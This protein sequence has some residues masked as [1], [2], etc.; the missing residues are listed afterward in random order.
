VFQP[1]EAAVELRYLGFD[2]AQSRRVYKFDC[3]AADKSTTR[4]LVSVDMVLFLK[5]RVGIQEGPVLCAQKLAADVEAARAGNHELT[6]DD[7]LAYVAERTAAEVRRAESRRPGP[8]RRK[9][10]AGQ[11]FTPW[12]KG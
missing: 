10:E 4:F 11:Q 8:H 5:H 3:K 1:K 2:Q 12:R 6:N 7:L 9:P